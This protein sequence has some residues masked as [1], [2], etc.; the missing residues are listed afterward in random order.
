MSQTFM[1]TEEGDDKEWA[2]AIKMTSEV[3]KLRRAAAMTRN[4]AR[5][6][7]DEHRPDATV[8]LILPSVIQRIKDDVQHAAESAATSIDVELHIRYQIERVQGQLTE[9]Q[10]EMLRQSLARFIKSVGFDWAFVTPHLLRID[11]TW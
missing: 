6:C 8:S 3:A 11:W 2:R 1:L 10:M 4:A 9:Q 7:D 5:D